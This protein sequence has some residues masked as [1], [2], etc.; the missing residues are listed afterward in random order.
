MARIGYWHCV[1]L[2]GLAAFSFGVTAQEQPS[3]DS[4]PKWGPHIDAEAKLGSRRD[5]GELDLFMPISQDANTL[6]F[7]DLRGRLDNNSSNEGNLGFGMRH[8]QPDG[9]NIG[10]YGYFDHRRTGLGGTFDQGTLGAEALGQDWDFRVNYYIPIGTRVR[11]LGP[12]SAAAI[13]GASIQVTT[14]TQEERALGGYDVEAG[15]RVPLFDVDNHNQLRLYG[16]GYW[17]GDDVLKV[18]GSRVRAEFAMA[19]VQGLWKGA[20]LLMGAEAQKDGTRGGQT[21]LSLRL[22]IPFGSGSEQSRQLDW[23]ERRMTAP[24]VR[25]VDIVSQTRVASTQVETATTTGGQAITALSSTTTTTT[26]AL[27]SALNTAGS[28]STVILSGTF[29]TTAQINMSSGQTIIGA[30]SLAV[31]TAS[32]HTAT[33]TAPGA[34]IAAVGN[35]ALSAVVMANNATLSGMTITNPYNAGSGNAV[36][37]QGMTGVTITNNVLS[38]G[39]TSGAYIIDALSSANAVISGNTITATSSGAASAIGIRATS[40]NNLTVT[41]NNFSL[42]GTTKYVVAGNNFTVFNTAASSGNTTNS[43]VCFFPGGAPTGSVGFS[44]I[45]CP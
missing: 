21:F 7:T 37:A 22:R 44:T 29:N 12:V 13:S 18:T 20:E 24:I 5:L 14:T 39:G 33:L 40:A 11:N 1:G 32:G 36:Y 45:T 2:C 41:G 28:N 42:T 31:R 38:A 26:A 30:G 23:Q 27:Q 17:F 4:A 35:S 19:Q 43:G 15:W 9:W 34:T 8:M 6:I 16:G 10:A 3:G 25:D